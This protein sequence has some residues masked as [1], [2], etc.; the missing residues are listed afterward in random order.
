MPQ[1]GLASQLHTVDTD[2]LYKYSRLSLAWH[3]NYTH[4][5]TDFLYKYSRLASQLHTIELRGLICNT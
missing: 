2:F 1:S 4:L 3:L 5:D